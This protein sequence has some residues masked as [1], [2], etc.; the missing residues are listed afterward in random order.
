MSCG[1]IAYLLGGATKIII[2][3]SKDPNKAEAKKWDWEDAGYCASTKPISPKT[4]KKLLRSI[5]RKT[6][7]VMMMSGE[8]KDYIEV[9]KKY[10]KGI[11]NFFIMSL[12][13]ARFSWIPCLCN[14]DFRRWV[15]ITS[16]SPDHQIS[17]QEGAK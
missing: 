4:F 5:K 3:S 13:K 11:I 2:G 17:N 10:N 7:I 14:F 16:T 12:T 8:H 6:D 15:A 9:W 1:N